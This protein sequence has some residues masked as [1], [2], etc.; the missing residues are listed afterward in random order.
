[1]VY[2]RNVVHLGLLVRVSYWP[3]AERSAVSDEID[4]IRTHAVMILKYCSHTQSS[5]LLWNWEKS[6]NPACSHRQL[7]LENMQREM[8]KSNRRIVPGYSMQSDSDG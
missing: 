1:M 4:Y 2:V 3:N 5:I 7:V 6:G 8:A